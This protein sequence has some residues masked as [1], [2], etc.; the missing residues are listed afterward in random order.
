MKKSPLVYHSD[1]FAKFKTRGL[2]NRQ[3]DRVLGNIYLVLEKTHT[4]VYNNDYWCWRPQKSSSGRTGCVEI[5]PGHYEFHNFS[6][7]F[8]IGRQALL[9]RLGWVS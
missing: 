1:I 2:F 7:A 6:A 9:Q 5:R 3:I 4:L 8:K